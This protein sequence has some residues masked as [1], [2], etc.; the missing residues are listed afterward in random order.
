MWQFKIFLCLKSKLKCRSARIAYGPN[1]Q[2]QWS[3]GSKVTKL[4]INVCEICYKPVPL[5]ARIFYQNIC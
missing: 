5:S 2:M 3:P 4:I 1:I